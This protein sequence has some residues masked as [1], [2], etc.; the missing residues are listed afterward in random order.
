MPCHVTFTRR[1]REGDVLPDVTS[2]MVSGKRE[3]K[4][5]RSITACGVS[6]RLDSM[7]LV[8]SCIYASQRKEKE[9]GK[10]MSRFL[11]TPLFSLLFRRANASLHQS[12]LSLLQQSLRGKFYLIGISQ[13]ALMFI[14]FKWH[15]W[16][17]IEFPSLLLSTKASSIRRWVTSSFFPR[18]REASGF[19]D[20][21]WC[22]IGEETSTFEI[23][24]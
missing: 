15:P 10:S 5:Q 8:Y 7:A 21:Q 18:L 23:N 11:P 9:R 13:Q 6:H 14:A 22:T 4:K 16:T 17:S 24:V 2:S 19:V 1:P 3:K 20:D 12:D